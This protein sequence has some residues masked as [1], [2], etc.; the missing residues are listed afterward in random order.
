MK[1]HIVHSLSIHSFSKHLSRTK[2]VPSRLQVD[3]DYKNVLNFLLSSSLG[4]GT[5]DKCGIK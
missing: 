1:T 5:S 4:P 2:Y 3:K